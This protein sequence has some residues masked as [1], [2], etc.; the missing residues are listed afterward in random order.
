M[1]GNK[2]R[3]NAIPFE[4]AIECNTGSRPL[5]AAEQYVALAS[6]RLAHDVPA[7]PPARRK[8]QQAA[9]QGPR[10]CGIA[11]LPASLVEMIGRR[12]VMDPDRDV[13][14][15]FAKWKF[16]SS[17]FDS[18]VGGFFRGELCQYYGVELLV[19]D[20]VTFVISQTL[21][22][23]K[24]PFSAVQVPRNLVGQIGAK[25]DLR[26]VIEKHAHKFYT[27]QFD[28]WRVEKQ[29]DTF[30]QTVISIDSKERPA[31]C[32]N[33]KWIV[34]AVQSESGGTSLV[35]WKV[36]NGQVQMPPGNHPLFKDPIKIL[37]LKWLWQLWPYSCLSDLVELTYTT[38][39]GDKI[40]HVEHYLISGAAETP[41]AVYTKECNLSSLGVDVQTLYFFP[42]ADEAGNQTLLDLSAGTISKWMRNRPE[43]VLARL[44]ETQLL[45]TNRNHD[46]LH[47]LV[48]SLPTLLTPLPSP[49]KSPS[50]TAVYCYHGPP[51][52]SAGCGI[53][54]VT[55]L[56][57]DAADLKKTA[58]IPLAALTCRVLTVP[59]RFGTRHAFIDAATGTVLFTIHCPSPYYPRSIFP[60]LYV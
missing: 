1:K 28:R 41:S 19:H 9:S 45:L 8:K 18:S 57:C 14:V 48:Y 37:S 31:V 52:V 29:S 33:S 27:H 50:P 11:A 42:I 54:V 7:P 26:C 13:T 15:P 23:L 44:D 25:K 5:F 22:L 12:W 10:R 17:T 46:W 49:T 47:C 58:G 56:E 3:S 59:P 34:I 21:G 30:A 36:L 4:F 2:K 60:M 39:T 20:H 53:I 6:A 51:M 43:L 55:T 35:V 32:S 24:G 16:G 40:L 38:T